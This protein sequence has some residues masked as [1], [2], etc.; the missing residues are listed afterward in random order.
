[1]RELTYV[2]RNTVEWRETPDP[3]VRSGREAIVAPVAA[4]SCDVD[5]AIPSPLTLVRWWEQR[6]ELRRELITDLL[7]DACTR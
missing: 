5:S 1:M 3:E 7:V 6:P 2:A 4:T